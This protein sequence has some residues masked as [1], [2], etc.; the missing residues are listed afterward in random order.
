M[1]RAGN[2]KKEKEMIAIKTDRVM[3]QGVKLYRVVSI[4]APDWEECP[5]K[6][7]DDKDVALFGH[8]NCAKWQAGLFSLLL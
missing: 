3:K 8:I 4:I 1:G 7:L 5:A 2:V 6:Y